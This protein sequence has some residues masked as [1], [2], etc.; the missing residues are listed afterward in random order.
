MIARAPASSALAT[1]TTMPAVLE[2]AR[3]VRALDLEVEQ[4]AAHRAAERARMDERREALA[5]AQR[6]GV[7]RDRQE[8][9][10]A[11]HQP[12][13]RPRLPCSARSWLEH[14]AHAHRSGL[15][16][17]RVG[18]TVCRLAEA[19]PV[20]Q[21]RRAT[22]AGSRRPRPSRPATTRAASRGSWPPASPSSVTNQPRSPA[23]SSSTSAAGSGRQLLPRRGVAV[24]ASTRMSA[25]TALAVAGPPAPGPDIVTRPTGSAPRSPR[26]S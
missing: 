16:E 2:R 15:R 5:E 10:E 23:R 3:R 12:G 24:R 13:T 20:A 25:S 1:A 9:R 19:Q 11:L 21:G 26:G 17:D 14:L 4:R 18:I 6:W 8:R 7:R 22:S